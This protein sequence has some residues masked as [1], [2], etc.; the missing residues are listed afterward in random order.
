[1]TICVPVE[2]SDGMKSKVYGHF[3]SAPFFAI[4]EVQSGEVEFLNNGNIHHEHG[5]CNP[6]GALAGKKVAAIL[7]GGIGARALQHLNA[8]GIKVYR[9][10]QGPLSLA[11]ELFKKNELPEISSSGCC[12]G[13][14]CH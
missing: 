6:L 1:M 12:Q 4:C 9:S 10:Q 14:G 13:H 2:N 7:V 11:I 3:G 5:Q 8:S